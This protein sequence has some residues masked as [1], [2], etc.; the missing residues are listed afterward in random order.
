MLDLHP[1]RMY[2]ILVPPQLASTAGRSFLNC[3]TEYDDNYSCTG[4]SSKNMG[5]CRMVR[6]ISL[7]SSA[8]QRVFKSMALRTQNVSWCTLLLLVL[9]CVVPSVLPMHP[10]TSPTDQGQIPR[11]VNHFMSNH[12]TNHC[13]RRTS[14]TPPWVTWATKIRKATA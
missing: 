11:H 14:L 10:P 13:T 3:I 1:S 4:A 6:R 7:R 12:R 9:I 5:T 2:V 8:W